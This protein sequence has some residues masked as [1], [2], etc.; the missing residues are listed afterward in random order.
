METIPIGTIIRS[1]NQH[2]ST[3]SVPRFCKYWKIIGEPE[4]NPADSQRQ[5][6]RA[7][8]CTRSGKE[9]SRIITISTADFNPNPYR[10]FLIDI[11]GHCSHRDTVHGNPQIGALKRRIKFLNRRIVSDTL[12]LND[13]IQ[14]LEILEKEKV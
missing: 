5:F 9:F 10:D 3:V 6:Y 8:R 7:I 12:L 4:E 13:S 11:V 14:Q 1:R 2:R